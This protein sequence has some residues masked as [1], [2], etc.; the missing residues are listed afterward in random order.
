[1]NLPFNYVS[2]PNWQTYADYLALAKKFAP[3]FATCS[4]AI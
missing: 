2:R 4:L 1:L 3:A